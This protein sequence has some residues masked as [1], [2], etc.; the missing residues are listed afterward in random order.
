MMDPSTRASA[1]RASIGSRT[2]RATGRATWSRVEWWNPVMT[3]L[4]PH[5]SKAAESTVRKV[6]EPMLDHDKPRGV[7][8][9]T[10]DQ[11]QLGDLLPMPRVDHVALVPPDEPD[12]SSVQVK[13]TWKEIPRWC[14]ARRVRPSTAV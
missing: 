14:F 10:F 8:S 9:M 5:V 2:R 6:V 7:S 4:W 11:F 1:S 12:G 13:M 3:T